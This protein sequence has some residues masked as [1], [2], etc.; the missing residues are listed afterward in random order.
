MTREKGLQ[1]KEWNNFNHRWREYLTSLGGDQ[2]YSS[3][4]SDDGNFDLK[5]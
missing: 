3:Y 5:L 1:P 2:Y 4:L